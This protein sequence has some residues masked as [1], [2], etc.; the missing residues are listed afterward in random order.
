MKP[1]FVA[2]ATA[3]LLTCAGGVKAAAPRT[4]AEGGQL[5]YSDD[6]GNPQAIGR[7]QRDRDPV[8]SPDGRTLAYVHDDAPDPKVAVPHSTLWTFDLLH[9][10]TVLAVRAHASTAPGHDFTR[11]NHPTWAL[12]G[13][14]VYVMAQA[15]VTSDSVHAV[16]TVTHTEH[17]I[18]PGNSLAVIRNGPYRGD[19][20]VSQHRYHA[21][22]GSYDPTFVVR[23]N[24]KEVMMV[25]GADGEDDEAGIARWLKSNG[26][27]A[28]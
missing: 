7:G 6:T 18:C 25:P 19:L 3:L 1:I 13:R 20:L 12:D 8:L 10:V 14:T 15:W 27:A 9:G 17:Y 4:W 21:A 2:C 28:S 24:G 23:P 5:F 11:L 22:G 16:D 26:W